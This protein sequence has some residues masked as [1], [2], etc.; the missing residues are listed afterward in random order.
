MRRTV[1]LALNV[2]WSFH[3]KAH[4]ST[5]RTIRNYFI[6][7]FSHKMRINVIDI[8]LVSFF[9]LGHTRWNRPLRFITMC[10]ITIR[11]LI[12]RFLC[13]TTTRSF[14]K[15]SL[16][17]PTVRLASVRLHIHTRIRLALSRPIS[18]ATLWSHGIVHFF[19]IILLVSF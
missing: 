18:S 9:V 12:S 15:H 8:L 4:K 16:D 13:R 3:S 2:V 7:H 19:S 1:V 17:W 5:S 10:T 6:L 14:C 11:S